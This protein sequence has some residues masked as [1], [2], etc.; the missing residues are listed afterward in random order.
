MSLGLEVNEGLGFVG[1]PRAGR[2]SVVLAGGGDEALIV[3]EAL[4]MQSPGAWSLAEMKL[5]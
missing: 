1:S 3:V 2:P 5:C 4:K